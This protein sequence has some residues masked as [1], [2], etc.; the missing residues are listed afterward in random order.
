MCYCST[1]SA[2]LWGKHSHPHVTEGKGEAQRVATCL[3]SRAPAFRKKVAPGYPWRRTPHSLGP[4]GTP[5]LYLRDSRAPRPKAGKRRLACGSL[6]L[7][8]PQGGTAPTVGTHS[9][10][11]VS[12]NWRRKSLSSPGAFVSIKKSSRSPCWRHVSTVTARRRRILHHLKYQ[13][14]PTLLHPLNFSLK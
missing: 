11:S 6:C 2:I 12:N 1:F 10:T 7:P 13:Y 5:V 3:T 14:P 4:G 8:T 9:P